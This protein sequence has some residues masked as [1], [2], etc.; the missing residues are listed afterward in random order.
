VLTW[1]GITLG[2]PASNLRPTLGDPLRVISFNGGTRHVARY[3]LTG[4][5]STYVLVV[6]E[7]GYVVSFD[8]FTDAAPTAVFENVPPDPFGVRLGETLASV[9][10]KHPQFRGDTDEGG[11]PFLIGQISQTIGAEYSFE[12]GRVRRFQWAAADSGD[13]PA[14]AALTA[15]SGDALASA[16]L[17]VQRSEA[18]GVAWEYRYLAFHPCTQTASWHLASQSLIHDGGRVYDD[19]HVVCPSTSVRR[20][21]YFDITSYFG[22]T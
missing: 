22:R 11:E 13:K 8:A 20:E 6:E 5:K 15:A 16:I 9:R 10:T 21:F 17:D 7:R 1:Y 3:W 2:E 19:L 14:L 12:G 18:D 4:S